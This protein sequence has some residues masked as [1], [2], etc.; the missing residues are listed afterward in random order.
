MKRGHRTSIRRPRQCHICGLIIPPKSLWS[1]WG[2]EFW[3]IPAKWLWHS[4]VKSFWKVLLFHEIK[5]WGSWRESLQAW[6]PQIEKREEAQG[7][8]IM[9]LG[10]KEIVGDEGRKRMRSSWYIILHSRLSIRLSVYP[11]TSP[12]TCAI[13]PWPIPSSLTWLHSLAFEMRCWLTGL[14]SSWDGLE[15]ANRGASLHAWSLRLEAPMQK[16]RRE[17]Y[18]THPD[19]EVTRT[20]TR[21]HATADCRPGQW[22]RLMLPTSA[23]WFSGVRVQQKGIPERTENSLHP[24][25]FLAPLE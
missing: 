24:R 2:N 19:A 8:E 10:W 4:Q 15:R 22:D 13:C 14:L 21:E 11:C 18:L 12:C 25:W 3:P 9:C 5:D 23:S 6:W 1:L 16:P 20:R 7:N 17:A